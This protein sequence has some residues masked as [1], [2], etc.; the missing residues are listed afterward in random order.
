M[1]GVELGP[2]PA[3]C[4]GPP[5]DRWEEF[6]DPEGRVKDPE[7]IRDLVFRGV[8]LEADLI[9]ALTSAV[10]CFQPVRVCR[11]ASRSL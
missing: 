10:A 11:R 9:S 5:L 7:K 6:L 3:V 2:R 4:R 8:R 1:K